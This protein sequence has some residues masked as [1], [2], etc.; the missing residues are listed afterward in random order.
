M[1]ETTTSEPGGGANDFFSKRGMSM[2]SKLGRSFGAAI[3]VVGL[4]CASARAQNTAAISGTAHDQSGAV[5]PGVTVTATQTDTGIMRSTITNE[6]GAF[7]LVNLPLGPYRVE[8][9]LSGFRKFVQTG[10]VLQV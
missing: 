5:L 9:E 4:G 7:S 10:I 3:L 1:P 6:T 2:M 8:A